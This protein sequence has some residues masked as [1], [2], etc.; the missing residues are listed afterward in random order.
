MPSRAEDKLEGNAK[1]LDSVSEWCGGENTNDAVIRLS[2]WRML[3]GA[4]I[5]KELS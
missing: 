4:Q 3:K 5:E 2:K 1:G